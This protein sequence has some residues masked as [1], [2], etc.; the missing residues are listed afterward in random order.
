MVM[1]CKTGAI[2]ISK[3]SS[4]SSP[5]PSP[6]SVSP[7]A[8]TS[9]NNAS[10]SLRLLGSDEVLDDDSFHSVGIRLS[11]ECTVFFYELNYA[12]GVSDVR[13][14]VADRGFVVPEKCMLFFEASRP[15]AHLNKD[16][17]TSLLDVA[18]EAGC[19]SVRACVSKDAL[20][21]RDVMRSY[22]ACGF[23]VCGE[24]GDF[25]VMKFDI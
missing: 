10:L 7:D 3:V 2:S 16:S 24:L 6:T 21:M 5:V 4:S 8:F 18:D 17:L 9:C 15:V 11:D 13:R 25:I 23:A 19:T 14:P 22:A 12:D 1:L 20:F